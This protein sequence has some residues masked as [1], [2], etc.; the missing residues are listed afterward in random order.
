MIAST[1]LGRLVRPPSS[2]VAGLATLPFRTPHS[3]RDPKPIRLKFRSC[4]L[5]CFLKTSLLLLL[6]RMT[7]SLV[8]RNDITRLHY[9]C[10]GHFERKPGYREDVLFFLCQKG[11][12]G[13]RY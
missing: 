10:Y 6:F 8:P 12:R 3:R 7:Q 2:T 11:L 5:F 13:P 1:T 9:W 4:P